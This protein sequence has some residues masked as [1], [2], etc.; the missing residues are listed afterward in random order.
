MTI[1]NTKVTTSPPLVPTDASSP[2]LMPCGHDPDDDINA[3]PLHLHV[4]ENAKLQG[5]SSSRSSSSSRSHSRSRDPSPATSRTP[6]GGRSRRNSN[7]SNVSADD[8]HIDPDI[9]TDK[10]G[11]EDL[12][13]PKHVDVHSLRAALPSVNERMSEETLEDCHAFT[14]LKD[15]IR[16]ISKDNGGVF[17]SGNNSMISSRSSENSLSREGSMAGSMLGDVGHLLETLEEF[18]EEDRS[19]DDEDNADEDK[20]KTEHAGNVHSAEKKK[21]VALLKKKKANSELA[22]GADEK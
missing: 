7:A 18:E 8:M 15:V 6:T 9:L 11:H 5:K 12:E 19:T 10:M 13:Q 2:T 20:D 4:G 14:D 17:G 21:K 16:Q 1:G 22:A 3:S